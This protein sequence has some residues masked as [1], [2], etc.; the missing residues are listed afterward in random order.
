M[1]MP[2]NDQSIC[3]IESY[4]VL[5]NNE[6]L[7]LEISQILQNLSIFNE[8]EQKDEKTEKEDDVKLTSEE[9]KK[10]CIVNSN[11]IHFF[12][13]IFDQLDNDNNGI[14]KADHLAY[15]K[16][17]YYVLFKNYEISK[18]FQ[19]L[20]LKTSSNI[21]TS[22]F[23]E[24]RECFYQAFTDVYCNYSIQK[25][26]NFLQKK[27]KMEYIELLVNDFSNIS[28]NNVGMFAIQRIIS[29]FQSIQELE[30][31]ASCL[32]TQIKTSSVIIENIAYSPNGA[33]VLEKIIEAYI[34]NGL[35][36]IK[37]LI[38][39][40]LN[41]FV[42]YTNDKNTLFI[43]KKLIYITKNDCEATFN[44]IKLIVENNLLLIV[45]T[46]YGNYVIQLV[47]KQ[48]KKCYILVIT[49]I[50][51]NNYITLSMN[52]NSS[53]TVESMIDCSKYFLD[54][55]ISLLIINKT[56][57]KELVNDKYGKY[58]IAKVIRKANFEERSKLIKRV[59]S[60]IL[61]NKIINK[62]FAY[63][64]SNIKELTYNDNNCMSTMNKMNNAVF[65]NTYCNNGSMNAYYVIPV[66]YP[67]YCYP[68]LPQ[69][70]IQSIQPNINRMD[71][72]K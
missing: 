59:S 10:K 7:D 54:N 58:V 22:I 65:N 29:S 55:L 27:E 57:F 53:S 37:F 14:T 70:P 61:K 71:L 47:L 66:Q 42:S 23:K 68:L 62:N 16:G 33:H 18:I 39:Y 38:D 41:N 24:L 4:S 11:D 13:S 20:L 15:L 12:I 26:Y 52:R 6:E 67:L 72:K 60:M 21:L 69:M 56:D 17:K 31:F 8:N 5:S 50:I 48:W 34:K 9:E 44:N 36:K 49:N 40:V 51:L 63:W 46:Q 3:T 45:S 2:M 32:K 1:D 43:V 25:M 35:I 28:N 30:L 19:K 64:Q